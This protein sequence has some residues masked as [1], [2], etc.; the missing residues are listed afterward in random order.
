MMRYK[1]FCRP[2]VPPIS[3]LRLSRNALQKV[4]SHHC[5]QN[6]LRELQI[7]SNVEVGVSLEIKRKHQPEIGDMRVDEVLAQYVVSF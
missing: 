5:E 4:S 1:H 6:G 2:C 7:C 3:G